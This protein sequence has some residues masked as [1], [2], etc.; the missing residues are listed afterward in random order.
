[1]PKGTQSYLWVAEFYCKNFLATNR[2]K[3]KK[4]Q[5]SGWLA[6]WNYSMQAR[7]LGRITAPAIY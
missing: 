3:K 1:M 2:L 4:I 7:E 6:G 5:G